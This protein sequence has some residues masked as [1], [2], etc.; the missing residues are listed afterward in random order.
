MHSCSSFEF[1]VESMPWHA[2]PH[3]L[4][5]TISIGFLLPPPSIPFRG[6]FSSRVSDFRLV[7]STSNSYVENMAWHCLEFIPEELPPIVVASSCHSI[8][9]GSF[10]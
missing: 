8:L 9:L 2:L 5:V 10:V 1:Y 3:N 6:N 7:C 4:Y